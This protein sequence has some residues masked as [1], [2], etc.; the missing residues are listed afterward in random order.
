MIKKNKFK[1]LISSVLILL[2]V[3]FGV[4]VWNE[5]PEKI[6]THWGADGNPDGFSS[7]AFAVFGLPL[8]ILA[9]HWL[10]LIFSRFDPK[11][12]NQHPKVMAI[13]FWICPAVSILCAAFIYSYSFKIE[14]N[15]GGICIAFM[16]ILFIILGNYMPKCK[17]NYTMGIK[18]PWTLNDEA[19]W[20]ATHRF[21]GKLWVVGGILLLPAAFL[22]ETVLPWILIVIAPLV[23]APIIYSGVYHKKHNKE[24][25]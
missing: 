16:G 3:L 5:L 2:P 23:L 4:A 8:I 10:C 21:A 18:I 19:N 22:P 15:V 12:T 11:N 24:D 9:I 7:K 1:V 17:Q 13:V 25:K 14:L 20:N 6:V